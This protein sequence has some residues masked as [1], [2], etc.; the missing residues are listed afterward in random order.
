[1]GEWLAINILLPIMYFLIDILI[2]LGIILLL[3]TII[4]KITKKLK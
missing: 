2:L 3:I 1:M 4:D